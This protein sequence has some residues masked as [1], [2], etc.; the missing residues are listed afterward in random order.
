[1]ECVCR[2]VSEKT[3][4]DS[5]TQW[6]YCVLFFLI[7]SAAGRLILNCSFRVEHLTDLSHPSFW[8]GRYNKTMQYRL[9]ICMCVYIY[10]HIC[11]HIT[12]IISYIYLHTYIIYFDIYYY[13]FIYY[14]FFYK[15]LVSV[16]YLFCKL[17]SHIKK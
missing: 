11:T 13:L 2:G 6:V 1:M 7:S 5:E 10:M 9:F 4:S 3:E 16:V 8:V 12:I 14:Y 15:V 17:I